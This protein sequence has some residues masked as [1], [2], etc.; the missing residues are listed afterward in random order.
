MSRA[1]YE[2]ELVARINRAAVHGIGTF[3]TVRL[4]FLLLLP[5]FAVKHTH[6]TTIT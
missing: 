2:A 3:C 4:V 6:R 5:T 1:G